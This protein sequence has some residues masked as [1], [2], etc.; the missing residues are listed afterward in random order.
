MGEPGVC[1]TDTLIAT[2]NKPSQQNETIYDLPR[3][4]G[5]S[6]IGITRV[7]GKSKTKYCDSKTGIVTTSIIGVMI[8]GVGVGVF[9]YF[10]NCDEGR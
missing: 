7:N 1:F 4:T 10:V 3:S 8:M 2:Q 5:A 6:T 9:L